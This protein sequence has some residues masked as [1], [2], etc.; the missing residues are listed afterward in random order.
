MTNDDKTTD[1]YVSYSYGRDAAESGP[2]DMLDSVQWGESNYDF[3]QSAV[4]RNTETGELFYAT[5]T[6][7]SCPSPFEDIRESDLT[8][9]TRLQDWIDHTDERLQGRNYGYYAGGSE[10]ET[11]AGHG[12]TVDDVARSIRVVSEALTEPR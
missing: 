4:F 5:D 2:Y 10:P 12:P 1:R 7:C 8:K 11:L 3:D 6:G 9:I